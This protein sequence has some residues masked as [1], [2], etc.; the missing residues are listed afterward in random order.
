MMDG[1]VSDMY[2][3]MSG[4][5]IKYGIFVQLLLAIFKLI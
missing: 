4:N 1:Y 5:V 2:H 3:V